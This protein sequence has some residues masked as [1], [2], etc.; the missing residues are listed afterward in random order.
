MAS[1]T[2]VGVGSGVGVAVGTGV[3]VEV[4]AG[5]A[6]GAAV[7]AG[8]AVATGTTVATG[9]E[10]AASTAVGADVGVGVAVAAGAAVV[11]GAGVVVGAVV[12]VATGACVAGAN[13]GAT[14]V[15]VGVGSPPPPQ[16]TK[17][18]AIIVNRALPHKG[19]MPLNLL[20]YFSSGLVGRII[21]VERL[22]NSDW[23]EI[24]AYQFIFQPPLMSMSRCGSCHASAIWKTSQSWFNMTY[25]PQPPIDPTPMSVASSSTVL[26]PLDPLCIKLPV[27]H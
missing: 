5:A 25:R 6:V 3:G 4:G 24:N 1:K 22:T 2:G 11:A 15:A 7:A 19:T 21:S 16:A 18:T 17:I 8:T 14:R 10:V 23:F 9:T 27:A 26:N 12:A 20:I 13:V